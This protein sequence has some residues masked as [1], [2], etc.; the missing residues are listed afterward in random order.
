MTGEPMAARSDVDRLADLT[1]RRGLRVAVA[2]SLTSGM[3]ASRLGAAPGAADWLG[4]GVVAYQREVKERV[5]GV[6]PR[7]DPCSPE[8]AEQLARGVRQL[9]A[10]DVAVS[11]TGV[12]GP[13]PQ[14]AHPPGTVYLGWSTSEETGHLL[15]RVDGDPREVLEDAVAQ[16]VRLLTVQV[17]ASCKDRGNSEGPLIQA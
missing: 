5:L 7:T 3:L 16:A 12:G 11:T 13:D 10:A 6:D 8:C 17:I 1:R 4:G 15:L 2:E 9:F 14:G